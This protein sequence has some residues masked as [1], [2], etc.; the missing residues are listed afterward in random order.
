MTQTLETEMLLRPL[1][2]QISWGAERSVGAYIALEF[3]PPHLEV[4]QPMESSADSLPEVREILS[5][6]K[7]AATGRWQLAVEH[8]EWTVSAFSKKC[9]NRS[10]SKVIDGALRALSG[11]ILESVSEKR[12][13]GQVEITLKFDLGAILSAKWEIVELDKATA[14]DLITHASKEIVFW[15][16]DG[17]ISVVE[18]EYLSDSSDSIVYLPPTK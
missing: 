16:R 9:S 13:A 1:I 18:S 6:R 4:R 2:G 15:S 8:C 12:S 3:G 7:A 10:S 17:K 14:V 11:Q 5:G